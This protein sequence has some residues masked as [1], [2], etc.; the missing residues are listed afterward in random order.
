MMR[1]LKNGRG[2]GVRLMWRATNL[3]IG[4]PIDTTDRD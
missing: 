1:G 3:A 4:T 2:G